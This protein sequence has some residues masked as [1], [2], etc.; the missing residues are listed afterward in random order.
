MKL[1]LLLAIAL[2]PVCSFAQSPGS[3]NPLTNPMPEVMKEEALAKEAVHRGASR[4]YEAASKLI[5]SSL[6]G[7]LSRAKVLLERYVKSLD[8][9]TGRSAVD[10]YKSIL[11]SWP[12]NDE[13]FDGIATLLGSLK[14]DA[15]HHP[16]PPDN[17][18][19]GQYDWFLGRVYNG[20]ISADK[21]AVAYKTL[22]SR[23]WHCSY[24]FTQ[25]NVVAASAENKSTTVAYKRPDD[26]NEYYR[27]KQCA[28]H[29]LE[30]ADAAIA[31]TSDNVFAWS[32]KAVLLSEM[33]KYAEMENQ[34]AEK[35]DFEKRASEACRR[36]RDLL[37]A[38]S[39]PPKSQD[40]AARPAP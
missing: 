3:R 23:D 28:M 32:H 7:R 18:G 6:P 39:A 12:D 30:M 29:G 31:G 40:E 11:Q 26:A 1:V 27:A 4:H 33:A 35:A 14:E 19:A 20:S 25:A 2:L 17:P 15:D 34:P 21:R 8:R 13:A 24:K 36:F 22:A 37:A 16:D 9:E 38:R 5:A 10:A